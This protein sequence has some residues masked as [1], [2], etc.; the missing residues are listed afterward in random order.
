MATFKFHGISGA[1]YAYKLMQDDIAELPRRGAVYIFASGSH[2]D[3][4]PVFIEEAGS[5]RAS[6]LERWEEAQ[7]AH[8]ANLIYLQ[9]EFEEDRSRRQAEKND[10]VK[11]YQPAMNVDGGAEK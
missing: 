2:T 1:G 9:S 8:G 6:A 5:V 4:R 11:K 7:N 3:P 10:L